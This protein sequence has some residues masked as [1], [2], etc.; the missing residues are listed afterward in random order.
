MNIEK[1]P[2]CKGDYSACSHTILEIYRYRDELK[3]E[4]IVQLKKLKKITKK[5]VKVEDFMQKIRDDKPQG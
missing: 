5:L 1:C 4:A 2:I 3:K